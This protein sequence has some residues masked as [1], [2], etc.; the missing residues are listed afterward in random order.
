MTERVSAAS[1]AVFRIT[2]GV[3]GVVFVARFF[4]HG[5]IDSLL[6]DPIFHFTY[7]GFDWVRPLGAPWMHMVFVALGLAAASI[8]VG[9]RHRVG[10]ALFASGLAYVELIDRA[11]YLNHYYWMIL[12][13]AL[14]AFLP[15]DRAWSLDGRSG[16]AQSPGVVPSWVVWLL[17]FQ[18]GMVYFFAGVAKL[19]ADW[20]IR[21]EP[22]STWLPARAELPLIGPLLAA[23]AAALAL[24][25]AGA[26]FDLTVVA[27]LLIR[28]TRLAAFI[29]LV[30]FHAV[31]WLLFPSIG[32][33]PLVMSLSALIFFDPDWPEHLFG[34]VKRSGVF[35]TRLRPGWVVLALVYV[36]AM[37]VIPI[38]HLV[39]PED[40]GWTGQGYQGSWQVMLTDRTGSVEFVVEEP[41]GTTWVAQPPGYLTD[42][43]RAL[44][45]TDPALIRQVAVRVATELGRPVGA[46]ARMAVNGRPGTVYTDPAV[47]LADPDVATSDWVLGTP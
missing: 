3:V 44:L 46:R 38:R 28:R 26:L 33:F 6:V 18:V 41:D 9:Y 5:W 2:F 25:W 43:Q 20:M 17:R 21:G 45:A 14:L 22:L 39:V 7:P 32:L 27:W 13:A 11:N 15:V 42:R 4:A 23:P 16:R 40:V 36:V 8:A 47:D 12:T 1:A 24:S 35:E 34:R 29:A 10:A 19:N 31:T 37:T 30:T